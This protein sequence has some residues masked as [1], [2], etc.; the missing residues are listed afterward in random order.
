MD[1][2]LWWLTPLSTIFQLCRGVKLHWW[3]KLEYPK[4][5]PT[6]CKSLKNYIAYICI[7]Y[8]SPLSELELTTLVVIRTDCIGSCKSNYHHDHDGLSAFVLRPYSWNLI[9]VQCTFHRLLNWWNFNFSITGCNIIH[10][11]RKA[12]ISVINVNNYRCTKYTNTNVCVQNI[13]TFQMT[14]NMF[15]LS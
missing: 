4:K 13:N 11:F 2:R 6:C 8:I 5:P 9:L 14:A 10:L 12:L 1:Y 7:E 15:R 3:R